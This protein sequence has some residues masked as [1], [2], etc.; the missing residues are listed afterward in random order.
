MLSDE[1]NPS[2]SNF[3]LSYTDPIVPKKRPYEEIYGESPEDDER[4]YKK[5]TAEYKKARKRRQ[6]RESAIRSRH[7][8]K[9]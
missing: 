7:R 1:E 9:N 4:R 2:Y 3:D 8:K 6:N 5:G